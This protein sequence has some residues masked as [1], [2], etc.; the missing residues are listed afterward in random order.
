MFQHGN[1]SKKP[2]IDNIF[3]N[4]LLAGFARKKSATISVGVF[5]EKNSQAPRNVCFHNGVS[6]SRN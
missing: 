1:L 6:N 5:E 3:I 2:T 4:T